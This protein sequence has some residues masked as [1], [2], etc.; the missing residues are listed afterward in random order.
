[1]FRDHPLS[2]L[3]LILEDGSFEL[4]GNDGIDDGIVK[5]YD[6][7]ILNE[8]HMTHTH[9]LMGSD[10]YSCRRGLKRHTH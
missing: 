7:R 8:I 5:W 4:N 1:M 2:G 3:S 10:C 9:S 6:E